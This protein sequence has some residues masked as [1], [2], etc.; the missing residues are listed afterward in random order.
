L[1]ATLN[2]K[3]FR[4]D[5]HCDGSVGRHACLAALPLQKL[6]LRNSAL[7]RPGPKHISPSAKQTL[8][9]L[10]RPLVA[11]PLQKDFAP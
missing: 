11:L 8:P 6:L 3:S 1:R 4:L 7:S 9:W 10:Q 5:K 2:H